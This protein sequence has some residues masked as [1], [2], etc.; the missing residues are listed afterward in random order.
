M[1]RHTFGALLVLGLATAAGAQG[2]PGIWLVLDKKV[3][4][5]G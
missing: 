2:A 3:E 4:V 1:Y 5:L